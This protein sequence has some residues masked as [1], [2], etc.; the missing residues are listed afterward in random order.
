[1]LCSDTK[2][3]L[4]APK[5]ISKDPECASD[6][7]N[8]QFWVYPLVRGKAPK[9]NKGG[10]SGIRARSHIMPAF[11]CKSHIGDNTSHT[12]QTS[13]SSFSGGRMRSAAGASI[14]YCFSHHF[15]SVSFKRAKP[16]CRN[17]TSVTLTILQRSS[18]SFLLVD[19]M[20]FTFTVFGRWECMGIQSSLAFFLSFPVKKKK[21]LETETFLLYLNVPPGPD[22]IARRYY[23]PWHLWLA[24]GLSSNGA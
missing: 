14:N 11:H 8:T 17:I 9:T 4:P 23:K 18:F 10:R 1:M 3:N 13:N 2:Q 20:S 16:E 19:I 6:V 5:S 7:L 22:D 24:D 21:K 12:L 15:H